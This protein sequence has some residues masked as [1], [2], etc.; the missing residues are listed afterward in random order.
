MAQVEAAVMALVVTEGA[1]T[2][3]MEAM[4]AVDKAFTT[5]HTVKTLAIIETVTPE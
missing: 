3:D 1:A 2:V 5:A 4:A